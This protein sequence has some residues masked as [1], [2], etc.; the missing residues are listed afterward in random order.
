MNIVSFGGG[1]NS[2]AMLIGIYEKKIPVDLILFADPGGEMPNTYQHI[3]TMNKWLLEHGMPQITT[4]KKVDENGDRLTLEQECLNSK[5]LPAI[6]FGWKTCSQKHKIAPQD[7]FCNNYQHCKDV[8][9]ADEK[10]Y[11]Y[12]G[13]DAGE[14][15]RIL[16]AKA[17]NLSDKKYKNVYSLY[18]WG[19]YRED[20]VKKIQE[21]EISLPGKS[22]CFFCPSMKKSEIKQLQRIYPEL[23]QRALAIEDNAQE[24]LETVK[25]LG[26]NYAWRDFINGVES[27]IEMCIGYGDGTM[28]CGC[29]DGE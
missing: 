4:V 21:Y 6:A 23:L 12:V 18:D 25:G 2:T 28:P 10:I 9:S 5:T 20:C 27:Q 17:I 13:Y 11:R 8:W 1:T 19:W 22:S 24:T 7:K 16:N 14:E 3:E 29:Y 26:R 15:N